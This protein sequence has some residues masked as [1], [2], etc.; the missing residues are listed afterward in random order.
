MEEYAAIGVDRVE[1]TPRADDPTS[2]VENFA[3]QAVPTVSGL[4][5][6]SH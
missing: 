2:R 1:V 5:R 4:D 3:S 6:Q